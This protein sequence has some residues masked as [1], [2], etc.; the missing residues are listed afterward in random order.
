MNNI[1]TSLK[2]IPIHVVSKGQD[3]LQHFLQPL[4]SLDLFGGLQH[5]LNF[6]LDLGV[7]DVELLLV[8]KG[9]QP[10]LVVSDSTVDEKC[11][12]NQAPR[13]IA[14]LEY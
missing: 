4:T 8:V 12:V 2:L 3:E 14:R 9:A 6:G 5:S 7:P 11:Q 13:S 1:V 10:L